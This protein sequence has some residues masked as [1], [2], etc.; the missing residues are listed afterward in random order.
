MSQ[1]Q[2]HT[3][4]R[5]GACVKSHREFLGLSQQ[6]TA[7]QI[8][9]CAPFLHDIETGM[10]RP[11]MNRVARIA[12]VIVINSDI[13]YFHMGVLPPDI[14][15]CDVVGVDIMDAFQTMRLSLKEKDRGNLSK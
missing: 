14:A 10:R 5:L 1:N 7:R 3:Y 2:W 12:E 4:E 9:I 11:G 15:A 8:G 6:D 13:L